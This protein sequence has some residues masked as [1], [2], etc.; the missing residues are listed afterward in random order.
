MRR[1]MFKNFQKV[2]AVVMTLAFVL[3]YYTPASA[4]GLA[5]EASVTLSVPT[6]TDSSNYS[7]ALTTASTG[8]VRGIRMSWRTTASSGSQFPTSGAWGDATL[9]GNVTGAGEPTGWDI[10]KT[11]AAT[12]TIYIIDADGTEVAN[13]TDMSWAINTVSNASIAAP[14]VGC[15][16][17]TTNNSAGTCFIRIEI[18]NTGELATLQSQTAANIIDTVTVAYTVNA[19]VE[20][21][22]KVD[23]ALTFTVVGVAGSEAAN[24]QTTSAASDFNK[25]PFGFLSVNTPKYLAQDIYTKTNANN[26]YTVTAKMVEQMNSAFGN[27]IDPFVEDKD[28][29]ITWGTPAAWA[30]PNGVVANEDTGW[31]GMNTS[32]G[33]NVA[34][35][36]APTGLWGP[37]QTTQANAVRTSLSPDTG[38][39]ATRITFALAVNVYQPADAYTGTLEYNCVPIY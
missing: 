28:S 16:P 31:I 2:L 24:G 9:A 17:N 33:T 5:T 27:D 7:F 12:G 11:D 32:N 20:V 37:L 6:A 3:V 10:N 13:G 34:G 15:T 1:E 38:V 39:T 29:P 25:L 30:T 21:T 18:Y 36:A 4:A 22:A 8:D 26:G 35:W 23:P 19:G 14:P